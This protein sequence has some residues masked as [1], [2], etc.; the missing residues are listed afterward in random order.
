MVIAD[1][2]QTSDS[3]GAAYLGHPYASTDATAQPERDAA[4]EDCKELASDPAL[5]DKFAADIEACGLSGE[6]RNAKILYLALTSRWLP[7]PVSIVV[8]G[9]SS[10]GK[11]FLVKQT[12]RFFPESAYYELSAMS[13]KVLAYSTEPVSHRF[14]VVYEAAGMA[15]ETATYLMRSLISEG[16]IRYETVE[17]TKEGIGS[18]L[19]EREGPTGLITTTTRISLHPENE[20]RML[21][22][23]ITDT[24][25]QTRSV[26]LALAESES[27]EVPDFAKWL[28][29]QK[30]IE[31][32]DHDVVIPFAKLLALIVPTTATRLRRDFQMILNLIKAHAILHQAQRSRDSKDRIQATFDDYSAVREL[33]EDLIAEG[34]QASVPDTVRETVEAVRK[35]SR[36]DINELTELEI[37][38]ELQLD[39]S[40]ASRRIKDAITRGFL[41]NLQDRKGRP[42]RIVLTDQGL[43]NN[44]CI[45][46]TVD[47][48]RNAMIGDAADTE[49][50]ANN[51]CTVAGEIGDT[52]SALACPHSGIVAQADTSTLGTVDQA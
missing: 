6:T 32:A 23:N 24:Q 21:S 4:W 25:N 39:K 7:R 2:F 5:L 16:R 28:S 49:S 48:L 38:N 52:V 14:I 47:E 31:Y 8:K 17:V 30:W 22:L 27:R 1:Q 29:L 46:P 3:N 19:I 51:G 43:P 15:G 33:I 50:N 13:E 10:G 40:T 20:T 37:A 18:R 26:F 35:L 44:Q 12:L 36:K 9:P 45:L 41:E 34:V 11:S 42:A